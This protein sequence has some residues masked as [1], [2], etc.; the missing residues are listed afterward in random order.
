MGHLDEDGFEARLAPC[1]ACG[2][3]KHELRSVIDQVVPVMLAEAA[4]PP[5]WAHDGE[6]F[7]DGTYRIACAACGAASYESDDCPRC[8]APGALPAALQQTSRMAVPKRCPLCKGTELMVTA[9][10]PSVAVYAGGPSKPRALAELGDDGFHVMAV[11]CETC[12]EIA[13]ADR[14]PI[15]DAAGPLRPRP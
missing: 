10:V 12:G 2:G 6:K 13:R 1:T 5:R 8:H 11:E 15:C 14:C 3:T 9:M 4:G 7:V